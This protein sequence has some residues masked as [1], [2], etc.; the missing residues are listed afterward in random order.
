[1]GYAALVPGVRMAIPINVG[2]ARVEELLRLMGRGESLRPAD[3]R[4]SD[5]EL[6]ML[7]G[8]CVFAVMSLGPAF[9]KGTDWSKL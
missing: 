8:V 2:K 1:M 9:R 6:L 5:A 4:W 3:G 7:A